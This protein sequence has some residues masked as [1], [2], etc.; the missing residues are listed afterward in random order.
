[1]GAKDVG[2][3]QAPYAF[4]ERRT[5]LAGKGSSALERSVSGTRDRSLC[6]IFSCPLFSVT[7]RS[8]EGEGLCVC[9]E[10]SPPY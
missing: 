7:Q 4:S 10:Q 2:S 1:M 8:S 5:S 3:I 6:T 9:K